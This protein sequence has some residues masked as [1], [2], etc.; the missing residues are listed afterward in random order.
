MSPHYIVVAGSEQLDR[1]AKLF[2]LDR[3]KLSQWALLRQ[4]N[5]RQ[6]AVTR[7]GKFADQAMD[8]GQSSRWGF[9]PRNGGSAGI[10]ERS[11]QIRPAN[12]PNSLASLSTAPE[13]GPTSLN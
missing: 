13:K 6:D 7:R 1:L 10:S 3:R 2:G 9:C 12:R 11:A 4:W 5:C 8:Q